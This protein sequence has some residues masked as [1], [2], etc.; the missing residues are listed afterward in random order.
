M[1][2]DYFNFNQGVM[3]QGYGF[4][5]MPFG[6]TIGPTT[7]PFYRNLEK[8][9]KTKPKFIDGKKYDDMNSTDESIHLV[10]SRKTGGLLF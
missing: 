5:S 10:K 7:I 1:Q 8:I 6:F 2:G 4:G 3:P 9:K